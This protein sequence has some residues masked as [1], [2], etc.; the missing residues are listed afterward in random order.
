MKLNDIQQYFKKISIT[1]SKAFSQAATSKGYFIKWQLPKD[2]LSSGN[3]PNLQFSK[4]QLP[5]PVLA[6]AL[7]PQLVLAAALGPKTHP[8]RRAWPILQKEKL[9]SCR[10]GNCTFGKLPIGKLSI[11]LMPKWEISNIPFFKDLS[12]KFFFSIT[13]PRFFLA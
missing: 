8:N 3:F 10:L 2:I 1:F 4:R 5:K 13:T 9:E 12:I 11:G 6:A 7:G